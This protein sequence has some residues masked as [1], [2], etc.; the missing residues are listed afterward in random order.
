MNDARNVRCAPIRRYAAI[1]AADS[2]HGYGK[3]HEGDAA[4]NGACP[5][6]ARRR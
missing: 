1:E 3:S 5:K 2:G 6:D 4:D